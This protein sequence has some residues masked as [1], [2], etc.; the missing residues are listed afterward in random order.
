MSLI[1]AVA[2]KKKSNSAQKEAT[3]A[4]VTKESMKRLNVNVSSSIYKKFKVKATMEGVDMSTLVN[5]WIVDY[6]DKK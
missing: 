1:D 5:Q 2:A 4:D 3:I 6:L